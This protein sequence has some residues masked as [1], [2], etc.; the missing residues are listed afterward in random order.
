MPQDIK[1]HRLPPRLSTLE[2][3]VATHQPRRDEG[4]QRRKKLYN[5]SRWQQTRAAKLRRDPLCQCCLYEGLTTEAVHVDHWTPLAE[6][7]AET[8]DANLISLCLPHHSAKT[9][10][11]RNGTPYPQIVP[12]KPRTW[13]I[14]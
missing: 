11:E 5:S 1:P 3:R 7:G 9:M 2:P 12:S 10:A 4:Q 14:A 6:G 8:E 13:G